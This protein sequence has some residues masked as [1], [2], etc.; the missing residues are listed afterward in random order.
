MSNKECEEILKNYINNFK[1]DGNY[2][3]QHVKKGIIV[4]IAYGGN[5]SY[6][7]KKNNNIRHLCRNYGK[8]IL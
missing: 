8:D 2:L 3:F 7:R 4:G 1:L 6:Y 5:R